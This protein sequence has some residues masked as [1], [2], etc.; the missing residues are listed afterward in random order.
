MKTI[1]FNYLIFCLVFTAILPSLLQ[2]CY[3]I[4]IL[5]FLYSNLDLNSHPKWEIILGLNYFDFSFSVLQIFIWFLSFFFTQPSE[6]KRNNFLCSLNPEISKQEISFWQSQ[7]RWNL[8]TLDP[9]PW[10][11]LPILL[12]ER[13]I[14]KNNLIWI[15]SS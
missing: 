4:W 6:G 10:H 9:L 3:Y 13:H 8:L 14:G 1:H 7:A 5:Y 2:N 15:W 11:L 12:W